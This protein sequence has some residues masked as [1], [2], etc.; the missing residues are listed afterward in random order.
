LGRWTG[1]TYRAVV[2]E[3]AVD[4]DFVSAETDEALLEQSSGSISIPNVTTIKSF[5][6]DQG[7]WRLIAH[8]MQ[9]YVNLNVS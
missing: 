7:L 8:A 2:F 6:T 5:S 1:Y 4:H 3:A 9:C